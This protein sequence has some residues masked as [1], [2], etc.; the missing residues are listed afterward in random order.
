M[1]GIRPKSLDVLAQR[2]LVNPSNVMEYGTG[3]MLTLTD[4]GMD[5]VT[6]MRL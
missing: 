2:G 3:L 6:R 5:V 4:K 1:I